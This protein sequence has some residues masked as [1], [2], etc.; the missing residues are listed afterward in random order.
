MMV[1]SLAWAI[2]LAVVLASGP[3]QTS[4]PAEPAPRTEFEQATASYNYGDHQVAIDQIN[5]YIA[6]WQKAATHP[7][8]RERLLES[9]ELRAR[10]RLIGLGDRAGAREDFVAAFRID[11]AYVPSGQLSRQ[12]LAL[13]E[14]VRT[15]QIG[16]VR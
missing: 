1:S 7:H 10:I 6:A 11:P 15:A 8:Y 12:A 14:E 16:T 13:V 2:G 3:A 5:T 9:F 4:P